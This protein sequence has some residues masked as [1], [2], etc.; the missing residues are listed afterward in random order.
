MQELTDKDCT[1][2]IRVLHAANDASAFS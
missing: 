2:D 1:L